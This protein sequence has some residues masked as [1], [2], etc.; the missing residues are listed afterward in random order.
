VEEIVL[1]ARATI[2]RNERFNRRSRD[3]SNML[4]FYDRALKRTAKFNEPL[5]RLSN[6]KTEVASA[7]LFWLLNSDS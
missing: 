4:V 5:T 2:E 1:V 7:L 3:A 6:Y